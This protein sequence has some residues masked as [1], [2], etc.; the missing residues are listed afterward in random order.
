MD[1]YAYITLV[2]NSDFLKGAKFLH[3]SLKKVNAK[4]PL[5]VIIT[6]NVN[7]TKNDIDDFDIVKIV[8][9]IEYPPKNEF[10]KRYQSTLNKFWAF[11]FDEYSKLLFIDADIFIYQNIDFIFYNCNKYKFLTTKYFPTGDRQ[12][13]LKEKIMPNGCFIFLTPNKNYFYNLIKNLIET[14][15]SI[16]DDEMHIKY[17]LYP[18]NY[19]NNF[20]NY[21]CNFFENI[22]IDIKDDVSFFHC[23]GTFKYFI[24]MDLNPQ[25]FCKLSFEQIKNFFN[26][27]K[28]YSCEFSKF[29]GYGK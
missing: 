5:I 22:G 28:N 19:I 13:E 12:N 2:S 8:P 6:D 23:M 14:N 16:T 25:A 24:D 10:F 21:E 3:Y 26:I 17:L 11:Y 20:F 4:Y 7:Y 18:E 1:K 9:Y 27:Y 15:L 29:L